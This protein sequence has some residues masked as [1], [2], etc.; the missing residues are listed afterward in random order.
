MVAEQ[1]HHHRP[2]TVGHGQVCV[3]AEQQQQQHHHRPITVGHGQVCVVAEQQQQHHHRP[4][5]E[6]VLV[7]SFHSV[8]AAVRVT[9]IQPDRVLPQWRFI[10]ALCAVI[11]FFFLAHI[12]SLVTVPS[13][14]RKRTDGRRQTSVIV[15]H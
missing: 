3:V 8:E 2:I 9:S 12:F 4:I 10:G 13:A 5:T 7:G 6:T 1:Q 11:R 14:I 15:S